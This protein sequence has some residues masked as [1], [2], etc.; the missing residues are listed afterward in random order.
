MYEEAGPTGK[1]SGELIIPKKTRDACTPLPTECGHSDYL[2]MDSSLRVRQPHREGLVKVYDLST[3]QVVHTLT[4]PAPIVKLG[5]SNDDKILAVA[6]TDGLLSVQHRLSEKDIMPKAKAS[7]H[8]SFRYLIGRGSCED[9]PTV[10]VKEEVKKKL[11]RYDQCLRTFQHKKA[12]QILLRNHYF[13]QRH[14]E[15]IVSFLKECIRRQALERALS[16][17]DDEY[18]CVLIKFICRNIGSAAFTSVLIDT[19]N[20]LLDIYGEKLIGM[21]PKTIQTFRRLKSIVNQESCQLK[22]MTSLMGTLE[23]VMSMSST[24]KSSD[25][26]KN[27]YSSESLAE[28]WCS[29]DSMTVDGISKSS[30][31]GPNTSQASDI[32]TKLLL[33]DDDSGGNENDNATTVEQT[34]STN[35]ITSDKTRKR[36]IMNTN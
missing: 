28:D 22:Q 35:L 36:K 10:E 6:M 29:S 5:I 8:M 9:S 1:A 7:K 20:D 16:E 17:H 13:V 19:T 4:Y 11:P 14:P 26:A 25:P 34:I 18:L 33:E 3:Y 23:L 31:Y 21:H 24:S 27:L 2:G 12:L 32:L 15:V 30:I